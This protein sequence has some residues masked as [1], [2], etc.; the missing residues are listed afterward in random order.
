MRVQTSSYMIKAISHDIHQ[1][2]G[3]N[4]SNNMY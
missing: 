3:L 2:H 4:L 1:T